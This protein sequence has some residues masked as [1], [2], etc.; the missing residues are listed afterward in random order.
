[1]FLTRKEKIRLEKIWNLREKLSE[2]MGE[3]VLISF[4][5]GWLIKKSLHCS[6]DDCDKCYAST[7]CKTLSEI[8]QRTMKVSLNLIEVWRETEFPKR[9]G[10]DMKIAVFVLWDRYRNMGKNTFKRIYECMRKL[11][12]GFEHLKEKIENVKRT[13]ENE[14]VLSSMEH[15]FDYLQKFRKYTVLL[16]KEIVGAFEHLSP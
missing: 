9:A 10:G 8:N 6:D 4:H 5:L 16:L 13:A 1:M 7:L 2:I 3:I 12:F 11:Y 15:I 14:S